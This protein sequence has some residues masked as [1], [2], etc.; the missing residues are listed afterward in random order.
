MQ[1]PEKYID[2]C[3]KPGI[4]RAKACPKFCTN[5]TT[6]AAEMDVLEKRV[7]DLINLDQSD[8]FKAADR[9]VKKHAAALEYIKREMK[10]LGITK[11]SIKDGNQKKTLD[12]LIRKMNRVDVQSLPMDIREAHMKETEVWM[13]NVYIE[14]LESVEEHVSKRSR[15]E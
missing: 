4:K 2:M 7:I 8:E 9:V 13:R 6:R 10:K 3:F 15:I 5:Y 12:F 14:E 1:C 11:V